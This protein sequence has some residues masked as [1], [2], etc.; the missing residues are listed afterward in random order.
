MENHM[1]RFET[2][3][4]ATVRVKVLGTSFSA[5][6][7]Q[8]A[9]KVADAVCADPSQWMRP[10]HGTV[11]VEGHGSCDIEAVEFAEGI[12]GVLVDEIDPETECVVDEHHFDENCAPRTDK[13]ELAKAAARISNLEACV[14]LGKFLEVE[15]EKGAK[16]G[17]AYEIALSLKSEADEGGPSALQNLPALKQAVLDYA[18]GQADNDGEE[19]D[20]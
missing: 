19:E 2:H 4:Y 17:L 3:V 11:K 12:Y 6:P 9:E 10:V 1:N 13:T 14:A 5:D 18:L 7:Q 15:S 20:N 16:D 8:I